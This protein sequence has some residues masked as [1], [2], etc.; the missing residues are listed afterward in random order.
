VNSPLDFLRGS[1]FHGSFF[2]GAI[3][4]KTWRRGALALAVAA[5]VAGCANYSG[6]GSDQQMRDPASLAAQDSLRADSAA[7]PNDRWWEN[8]GD[9]QLNTLIDEALANSP[10]LADA[11]AR[12]NAARATLERS[13][14][15]LLPRLDA[16][17]DATW[18][19]YTENGMYPEPLGGSF[20]NSGNVQL[21]ASYELDF[22]GRNRAAVAA[23]RSREQAALAEAASTRLLLASSISKTWFQLA[24]LQSYRHIGEAALQQRERILELTQQR[25]DAGLDTQVE[26]KQAQMQLPLTRSALAQVDENI[27]NTRHALAAL[28]GAGPDRTLN[29]DATLPQTT[30]D[31][32]AAPDNLP[33]E[34]LG[35]RPDIV[36]ARWRVEAAQHDTDASKAEFYPNVNLAAFAGFSSIGLDQLLRSGSATYGGGP[37]ISLPIFDGGRLR[38]TL[39]ADYAAYDSAIANYNETLVDALHDVADQLNSQR[40]LQPQMTEQRAAL[41]AA[42]GALDLALQRYRAGLGNYLT[43]LNA[44][45]AVFSQQLFEAQLQTRGQVLRV[46]LARALGGGFVAQGNRDT[47]QI[48]A[49]GEQ[50]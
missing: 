14:S 20:K 36:A 12:V 5:V 34:L 48:N 31:N 41:I 8:F 13:Q 49:A 18:Q 25:V 19:R 47:A 17:G 10:R 21:Q 28:L 27:V 43:V 46:E 39:K 30:V 9:S 29:I 3:A 38:A 44:E 16:G 35:H 45:S 11:A 15:A 32:V 26:L 23:G 7:W 2:H 1:F 33:V 4:G 24:Q 6:I 37:A 22:W 40:A 42:R 50:P